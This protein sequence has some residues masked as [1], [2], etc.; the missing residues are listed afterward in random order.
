VS[1]IAGI[2]QAVQATQQTTASTSYV[3]ISCALA[4]PLA[5]GVTYWVGY[6]CG[7]SSDNSARI[8][9]SRLMHGTAE[10]GEGGGEGFAAAA[11]YG[12]PQTQGWTVIVGNGTDGLRFQGKTNAG[13][14]TFGCMWI[15]AIPLPGVQNT[16]WWFSGIDAATPLDVNDAA[17][18]SDT[19][20]R[21][22]TW[23][24][25]AEDM[26]VFASVEIPMPTLSATTEDVRVRLLVNGTPHDRVHI[27]ESEDIADVQCPAWATLY[28]GLSGSTTFALDMQSFA[29][30]FFDAR[31]SRILVIRK[32]AFSQVIRTVNTAN[33]QRAA[34][35]YAD[36]S[37]YA[38][39][40]V[41]TEPAHVFA[42]ANH[43]ISNSSVGGVCR[44]R[45]WN[46]TDS[47]V[48]A[49]DTGQPPNNQA[50]DE[51][52]T[53][54]AACESRSA[55]TEYRVQMAA[56]SAA[57]TA[58]LGG[59]TGTLESELLLIELSVPG[60]APAATIN[61]ILMACH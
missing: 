46:Q 60:G 44:T 32:A 41:P 30:A 2:L 11:P 47:T 39:T 13:T 57:H 59:L 17:T 58:E 10:I 9:H 21:T 52:I 15:V 19:T 55:S 34:T 22:A 4:S 40:I 23:T 16:D 7:Q 1:A 36:V 37:G 3:D 53:L 51:M 27:Q 25:P 50:Q 38:A 61:P 56:F 6:H 33:N 35:S 54:V 31:R 12:V 43:A 20:I 49:D 48:F 42:I 26:L 24:L 28:T 8:T 45:L 18:G 14:S 29:G 5:N